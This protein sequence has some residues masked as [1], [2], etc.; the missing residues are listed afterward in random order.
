MLW[1][2]LVVVLVLDPEP[3][4]LVVLELEEADPDFVVAVPDFVVVVDTLVVLTAC[5]MNGSLASKVE[6]R[7]STTTSV[8]VV[9]AGTGFAVV[10]AV[11]TRVVEEMEP[12]PTAPNAT[13]KAPRS[14]TAIRRMSRLLRT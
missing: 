12:H 1:S 3:V 8:V 11:G 6:S 4:V 2:E 14:E 10:E 5:W 9:V 13:H 7:S